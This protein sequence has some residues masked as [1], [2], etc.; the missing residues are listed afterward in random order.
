MTTF[1]FDSLTGKHLQ[2]ILYSGS[3]SLPCISSWFAGNMDGTEAAD[4]LGDQSP[5]H[6][7]IRISSSRPHEGVFVLVV[8]TRDNGVVQIQIEVSLESLHFIY[9]K[10]FICYFLYYYYFLLK[11][12]N[13]AQ[14]VFAARIFQRGGHTLS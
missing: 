3:L 13:S 8:K 11:W 4:F 10:T 2:S 12:Y 1:D 14:S 7:L 5:G 6:F 9:L